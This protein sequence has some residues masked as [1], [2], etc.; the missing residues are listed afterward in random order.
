[1]S[2]ETPVSKEEVISY[3]A[4]SLEEIKQLKQANQELE[5]KL[6]KTENEKV[7]LEKVASRQPAEEKFTFDD[8]KMEKALSQLMSLSL[9][10]KEAS[11]E[12]HDILNEDPNEALELL[13]KVAHTLGGV[14]S[15]GAS[16][17][18]DKSPENAADP[19]GWGEAL[20]PNNTQH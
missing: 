7:A 5:S 2:D 15:Q 4:T 9:L 10:T 6:E 1:M 20:R 3:I 18:A 14:Y 19:F 17:T 12:I 13:Y 16:I 8:E 11:A